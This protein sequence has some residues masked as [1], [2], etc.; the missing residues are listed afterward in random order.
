MPAVNV[1]PL[2]EGMSFAEGALLPMA[3]ATAWA[4]WYTIGVGRETK[5]AR[6]DKKGMLV[7]GGASSVGTAAVQSARSMGFEVYVTASEKHHAYLKGLGASKLWDYHGEGVVGKIVQAA[8]EDGVDLS[9]GFHAVPEQLEASIE[10][11]EHFA[12][13][14]TAKLAS[15]ALVPDDT[16]KVEGVEVK[17]VQAPDDEEERSEH[18]HFVFGVWLK[19]KLATGEYVPSP[20][21][22]VVEGGLDGAQKALDELRAGVSGTK[23]VLEV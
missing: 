3:V 18:F 23:L 1:V 5:F 22:K 7:W 4:G 12:G 8:K 17:F 16:P 2:P 11:L 14:G 6:G 15:A 21:I 13:A 9:R 19:E 20:H 10:V